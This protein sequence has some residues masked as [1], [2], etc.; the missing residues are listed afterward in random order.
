MAGDVRSSAQDQP[1]PKMPVVDFTS[2]LIS[3]DEEGDILH[4]KFAPPRPATSIGWGPETWLRADPITG[5]VFGMEI[6]GFTTAYLKRHRQVASVWAQATG[7]H[8]DRLPERV[9]VPLVKGILKGADLL[10][11]A[12]AP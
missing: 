9:R 1:Q 11:A 8:L 6:E 3:Y 10:R 5:D 2:V 7:F 4:L 12:A